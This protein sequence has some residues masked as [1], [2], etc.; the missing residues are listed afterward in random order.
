MNTEI[1]EKEE[2][3]DHPQNI[4]SWSNDIDYVMFVDENNSV[5]KQQV[6]YKK[7]INN[8]P[9][10]DDE[11]FFTV[12]GC[13]FEKANYSKMRN[14]IR[15][16]KNKF[17]SNGFFNDTHFNESRYVCLHSREIRRHDKAFNDKIINYT[18][19]ISELSSVLEKVECKIISITINIENFIKEGYTNNIYENA[20]YFLIERYIYATENKKK[21]II[22]LESRGKVD[23]RKLL[24]HIREI[25]FER[26]RDKISTK[27][28]QNKIVG[29]YFNP[30]WY[31]GHSSTY[32][33]L[34]IADLFSYPIHQYVKYKKTNSSFELIKNKIV[35]YPNF[36]GKGLKVFPKEKDD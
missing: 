29:I 34:E 14:D 5:D 3:Y 31:G 7:I 13:I 8:I 19:F 12:T 36:N 20:F 26:G 32:A 1:K 2:W 6:V 27:E 9:I 28:L 24:N 16:L 30:K 10:N 25:V 21:G 15:K 18:A 17:W 23:D 4:K 11:K 35:G 22:M 33:G